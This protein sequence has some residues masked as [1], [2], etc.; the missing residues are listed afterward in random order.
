MR[1]HICG[2]YHCRNEYGLPLH[3]IADRTHCPLFARSWEKNFVSAPLDPPRDVMQNRPRP[4]KVCSRFS[5]DFNFALRNGFTLPSTPRVAGSQAATIT[6]ISRD[7]TIVIAS[8]SG[9]ETSWA[10]RDTNG[11]AT[12]TKRS[13][14]QAEEGC[15]PEHHPADI[16]LGTVSP[17]DT[18]G[19]APRSRPCS[20]APEACRS[21][22]ARCS[23]RAAVRWH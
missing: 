4:P 23:S 19:S 21:D 13:A 11:C 3:W 5:S 20:R 8:P 1:T 7:P 22:S 18:S 12:A 2:E 10:R 6:N 17:R 15:M 16:R 9:I 14:G